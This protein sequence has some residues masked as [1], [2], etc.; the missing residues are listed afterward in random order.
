MGAF[1]PLAQDGIGRPLL[2]QHHSLPA[3]RETPVDPME[4]RGPIRNVHQNPLAS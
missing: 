1:V 3:V 4:K 2:E